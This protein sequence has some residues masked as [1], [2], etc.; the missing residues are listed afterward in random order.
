MGYGYSGS[1][2]N[3]NTI[4]NGYLTISD[5]GAGASGVIVKQWNGNE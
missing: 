5:D 1:G 2:A 4:S 3:A